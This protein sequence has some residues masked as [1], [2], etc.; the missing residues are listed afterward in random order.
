MCKH[1]SIYQVN[2]VARQQ[3]LFLDRTPSSSHRYRLICSILRIGQKILSD[4]HLSLWSVREAVDQTEYR[5]QKMSES[6]TLVWRYLKVVRVVK[7]GNISNCFMG[8][9]NFTRPS[10]INTHP[11]LKREDRLRK[12]PFAGFGTVVEDIKRSGYTKNQPILLGFFWENA[13]FVFLHY[14]INGSKGVFWP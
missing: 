8:R 10:N 2:L 11:I 5:L 3:E 13:F 4:F 6:I 1:Q 14:K 12:E 7:Q 9:R